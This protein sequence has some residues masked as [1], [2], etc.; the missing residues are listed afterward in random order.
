MLPN[1]YL[2]PKTQPYRLL[3]LLSYAVLLL[4]ALPLSAQNAPPPLTMEEAV[5]TAIR[6]GQGALVARYTRDAAQV[7]VDR[8]KPIARPLLTAT[9]GETIQAYPKSLVIPGSPSAIFLPDSSTQLRFIFEQTLFQPGMKEARAR[10]LAQSGGVDWDYRRDLYEIA[11][12]VRK[13][14]L[15]VLRAEA[16]TRIAQDGVSAAERYQTLVQTQVSA[17]MAR[18]VDT[19]TAE[20]QLAEAKAGLHRAENELTLARLNF[21]RLLGRSSEAEVSLLVP[22]EAREIPAKP[23]AAVQNAFAKRPEIKMLELNVSAAKAGITL[24]KLQSKPSIGLRGQYSQQTPT[25][26]IHQNYM[27]MAVEI[28][29]PIWDGGK[30]KQDAQ[31]A[32]IQALRLKALLDETKAGVALEV[33]QAWL[34]LGEEREAIALANTQTKEATALLTVAEKAYEVNKGTAVEVKE[35]QRRWREA[36]EKGSLAKFNYLLAWIDFDHACGDSLVEMKDAL[37]KKR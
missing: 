15:D 9:I 28:R 14:Y 6:D 35:A 33:K 36:L 4:F 2:A 27:E 37:P 16:G 18:P 20:S 29:L 8:E 1:N 30:A 25:A 7:K 11:R 24:A 31:E 23:D 17:G 26:L 34:K 5:R 10:Y 3:P 22:Q 13:A 19:F 32:K 21:N 12:S